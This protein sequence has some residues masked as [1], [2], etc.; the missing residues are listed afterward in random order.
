VP[1]GEEDAEGPGRTNARPG[2]T[3]SGSPSG[4]SDGL[5]GRYRSPRARLIAPSSTHRHQPSHHPCSVPMSPLSGFASFG[6]LIRSAAP[7]GA[8]G[9]PHWWHKVWETIALSCS[10]DAH[11][12]I[13]RPDVGHIGIVMSA[14]Q[15]LQ[16]HRCHLR[17]I[18]RTARSCATDGEV[19]S[20]MSTSF[21]CA[22]VFTEVVST[23]SRK[24]DAPLEGL[25]SLCRKQLRRSASRIPDL[26]T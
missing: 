22:A 2:H 9:R 26:P 20:P 16:K 5:L 13:K 21:G 7:S 8:T 14:I 6:C 24:C 15:G 4:P 17:H 25:T 12:R 18:G 23:D 3:Y 10:S 19:N 1:G 11:A